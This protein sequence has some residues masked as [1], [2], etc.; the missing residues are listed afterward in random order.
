MAETGTVPPAGRREWI[1]LAVL[2]L[3]T[4]VAML[5]LNVVILALPHLGAALRA[6]S[7]EQL[8]ITDIYGFLIAGFLVTMGRLGDRIGHRRLLLTG[9]GAF[10]ALSV[11]AAYT[12]SPE[13]LIAMRALLGIAGATIMPMTLALIRN[14]FKDARQMATAVGLWSMAMMAGISLGPAVGGLLLNSFWWGSVFLISVP[15]M[16]VLLAVGPA[17]L[18]ESRHPTSGRLDLVSVALSLAAVLPLI[19]GLKELARSGLAVT[20]VVACAV[21]ATMGTVFVRRQRRLAE[22]LLDLSLFGTRAIGGGLALYLLAGLALSGCGLLLSQH[23]QLVEGLSPLT[24]A[25]W[26]LAPAAVMVIGI[27]IVMRVAKRVRPGSILTVGMLIAAAGMVVLTQVDAVA[28]LPTLM[29][30][31]GIVFAGVNAVPALT[32]QLV[33]QSAPPHKAGSVG[34]LSTTAGELG[35]ALGIAGLGSLATLFYQGHVQVPA[36]VAADTATAAN[37]SIAGAIAAARQLPSDVGNDLLTA[38]R[39]TFSTAFTQVAGLCAVVFLA[40][41]VLAFVTLRDVPLIGTQPGHD[42]MTQREPES[43]VA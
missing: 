29:L 24:A 12:T 20:S 3:P 8:W 39:A 27:Q 4:M 1:G 37:E 31:V 23:L 41:A 36:Q 40:L 19:Y 15:V 38:A 21:G 43:L 11:A 42:D 32:N 26:M 34:S 16:V 33:M 2:T 14:M 22:P 18:P 7:S 30:G 9:A 17:L 5:D 25:L 35:S 6:G 13:Q 28:G 10:A